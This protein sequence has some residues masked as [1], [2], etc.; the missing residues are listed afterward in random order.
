[1]YSFVVA[2]A[3]CYVTSVAFPARETYTENLISEHD[4][5]SPMGAPYDADAEKTRDVEVWL[6]LNRMFVI[7]RSIDV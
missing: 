7:S 3:V 4:P 1:M 6:R 5:L 2:S